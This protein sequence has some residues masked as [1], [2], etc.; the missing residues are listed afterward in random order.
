VEAEIRAR[1]SV[2]YYS[3]QLPEANPMSPG[4]LLEHYR[5]VGWRLGLDPAP[6]FSVS[7][8][9]AT[10]HDVMKSGLE[11]LEH[12]VRH[13]RLERRSAVP[14]GVPSGTAVASEDTGNRIAERDSTEPLSISLG[15][16]SA[17]SQRRKALGAYLE[18]IGLA[19][20]IRPGVE[21]GD[22]DSEYYRSRYA[23][24]ITPGQTAEQHFGSLGWRQGLCPTPWFDTTFYSVIYSD[25]RDAA[26]NPF[27]HFCAQ[28]YRERRIPSSRSHFRSESSMLSLSLADEVKGWRQQPQV[29]DPW[30]SI[31]DIATGA[32]A[33]S[34]DGGDWVVA[35]GHDDPTVVVGGVQMCAGLESTE[36]VRSGSN[37]LY[38][39]PAVPLPTLADPD[40]PDM[41]LSVM[42]NGARV[43]GRFLLSQLA[44][45]SGLL[46]AGRP[47]TAVVVH[48][49]FGHHP[50]GLGEQ[51]G[52]IGSHRWVWWVHDYMLQCASPTLA[53]N[54]LRACGNPPP[55]SA[56]CRTCRFGAAR[57]DHVERLRRLREARP[58]ETFAP[59][60]TAANVSVSGAER[61]EHP[62]QVVAHGRVVSNGT[63]PRRLAGEHLRIGYVGR[64]TVA[65]GWGTFLNLIRERSESAVEFLHLG[66][67][68]SGE[69]GV[70]FVPLAQTFQ[71]G[72]AAVAALWVAEIDAV[73]IWPEWAETFSLVTLEAIAAGCVVVCPQDSGNVVHLAAHYERAVVYDDEDAMLADPNLFNRIREV[74][75][76]HLKRGTMVFDG[77]TPAVLRGTR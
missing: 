63:S 34:L 22:V 72:D 5:R 58:W 47:A 59:S 41:G 57:T 61:L 15:P 4:E 12:F 48:S 11:P 8:Y 10:N 65:K 55:S 70:E 77:L 73:V 28:G 37:Y 31:D 51:L 35:F 29:P 38:V 16:S 14:V 30:L 32:R 2:D 20:L 3:A 75:G 18:E 33:L 64:A 46:L 23:R 45:L 49:L 27:E 54:G 19:A 42:V 62:P 50:E 26:I 76:T 17:V 13:G 7:G 74:L 25:I 6:D 39:F 40:V 24:L 71:Q 21:P 53:H 9:L 43:T 68:P 67:D 36:F 60:S 69:P 44:D 66:T 1:F 56:L 52:R